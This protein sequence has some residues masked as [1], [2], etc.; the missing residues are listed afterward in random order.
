MELFDPSPQMEDS[1]KIT[2]IFGYWPTF[3]DAEINNLSLSTADREPWVPGSTAPVLEMQVHVFEMTK[4]VDQNGYIVLTKH[5]LTKLQFR[6]VEGLQLAGFSFQNA[7]F[8]LVFGIEPMTF[9]SG[10]GPAEGPPPNLLTV[11]I[12]S[13]CGLYGEFKCRSAAVISAEPC[14]EN[15]CLLATLG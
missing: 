4:E 1:Q 5:T 15:G 14:D 2:E 11:K 3:H 9:R 10:G 6:N 7:I 8:E 12:E 13:N